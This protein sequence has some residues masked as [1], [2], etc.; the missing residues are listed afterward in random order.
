MAD[1]PK[2]PDEQ[3]S[4]GEL[5]PLNYAPPDRSDLP[6]K[7]GAPIG[8]VIVS[9]CLIGFFG[10]VGYPYPIDRPTTGPAV[11]INWSEVAAWLVLSA[12]AVIVAVLRW[13]RRPLPAG[14]WFGMGLLLGAALTALLE[15]ACYANP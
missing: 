11:M 6:T 9:A 3:R 5:H 1:D 7:L 10:A 2:K 4:A 8:G 12:G 15:G 14:R 13:N